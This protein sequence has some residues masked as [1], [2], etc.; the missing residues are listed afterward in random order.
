MSLVLTSRGLNLLAVM[1]SSFMGSLA[2]NLLDRR[3]SF[4]DN[5]FFVGIYDKFL[6]NDEYFLLYAKIV[7]IQLAKSQSLVF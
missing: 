5:S 1:S 3:C 6:I 2:A 4:I 7:Q